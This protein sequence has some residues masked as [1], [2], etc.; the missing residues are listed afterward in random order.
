MTTRPRVDSPKQFGDPGAGTFWVEYPS[1]LVDITR[2]HALE[3]SADEPP[4]LSAGQHEIPVENDRTIRYDAEKSAIVIIDMQNFFLHPE[5]RAHPL[6]L[7]C[8]D[9]L[10]NVVTHFRKTGVKIIW[11]NWGLTETELHTI[12]P[13]L[14]RSFSKGGRGG[15][16]SEMGGKWGRLLMR[17]QFNSELYGPLQKEY[18]EGK[19]NGTDI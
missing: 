7:K 2:S 16:G 3:T 14:S 17:D 12:P 1:G 19:K 5:L 13:S 9:P 11:V 18:E 4:K 8:V 10:I 15:F 6:G